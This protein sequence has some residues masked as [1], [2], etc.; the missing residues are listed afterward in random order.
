MHRRQTWW[1]GFALLVFVIITM[2]S[3]VTEQFD[4][5]RWGIIAQAQTISASPSPALTAKPTPTPSSSPSSNSPTPNSPTPN[6][7]SPSPSSSPSAPILPPLPTAQPNAT[8]LPAIPA[9]VLPAAPAL[10][11]PPLPI[12]GEYKD[13]KSRFRI[14]ILKGYT[15]NPLAGSVLFEAPDGNLAYT[16]VTQ[17]HQKLGLDGNF[18]SGEVLAELAQATFQQ[19]EDFQTG[20]PMAIA[21]GI[22]LEWTGNLTIAGQSQPVGGVILARQSQT[23][24]LQILIA[25]TQ[26]GAGQMPGAIRALVESWQ[27]P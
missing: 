4:A 21:N 24:I 3:S 2:L 5:G 12:G 8:P 19:G 10:T 13:P 1:M 11:A 22:Y 17:T 25:S 9:S 26:A 6:S 20:T 16:I 14:G 27:T 18:I 7:P 15:V 23:T